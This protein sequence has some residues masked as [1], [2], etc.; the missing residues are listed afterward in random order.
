MRDTK[1]E[2]IYFEP[3]VLVDCRRFVGRPSLRFRGPPG[4]LR[5]RTI[6]PAP[7]SVSPPTAIFSPE[8][9]LVFIVLV[10]RRT[11]SSGANGYRDVL[12]TRLPI[13]GLS[14]PL[15]IPILTIRT[16]RTGILFRQHPPVLAGLDFR[17]RCVMRSRGDLEPAKSCL[18][19]RNNVS[20]ALLAVSEMRDR[21]RCNV[22]SAFPRSRRRSPHTFYQ[23]QLL[24]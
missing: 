3:L 4:P 15:I 17:S 5:R 23:P 14:F 7:S 1:H 2:A 22:F 24:A 11:S 12:I 16:S 13:A 19:R 21:S 9:N 20:L 18:Y 6:P 8:V 10:S